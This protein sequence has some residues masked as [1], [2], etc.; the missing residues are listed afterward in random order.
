MTAEEIRREAG[1][2]TN[3]ELDPLYEI[4]AQLAELNE[5]LRKMYDYARGVTPFSPPK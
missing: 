1:N 2:H 3:G 5:T 4:A